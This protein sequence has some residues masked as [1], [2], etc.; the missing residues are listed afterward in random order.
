MSRWKLLKLTRGLEALT[1]T[2][3]AKF[4]LPTSFYGVSKTF[5]KS[6]TKSEKSR[7]KVEKMAKPNRKYKKSKKSKKKFFANM[8]MQK[9]LRSL[10]TNF[11]VNRPISLRQM[12][13]YW[14]NTSNTS[15]TPKTLKTKKV[16]ARFR[17]I[18]QN[19]QTKNFRISSSYSKRSHQL[20]Y[21]FWG[22]SVQWFSAD[23]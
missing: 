12:N 4:Q 13:K 8:Y 14:M 10:T 15:N 5:W 6:K 1:K 11:E 16:Y 9:H 22:Q 7:K 2:V 23:E 21:Q 3:F 17:L 19:E 18:K 20:N